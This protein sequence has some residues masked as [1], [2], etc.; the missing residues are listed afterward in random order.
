MKR[1]RKNVLSYEEKKVALEH[2]L[3]ADKLSVKEV[4][5]ELDVD[6][7]TVYMWLKKIDYDLSNIE[8]LNRKL[9]PI[10]RSKTIIKELDDAVKKK[11]MLLI[12]SNPEM[13][14]LKIKQYLFRHEQLVVSEKKIYFFLKE[15]GII[16]KRKKGLKVA[17]CH[18]RRFEYPAPLDAVQIDCLTVTVGSGLKVYVISILDDYS[19][20]ILG[21]RVYPKKSME[22]VMKIFREVTK[23][24]G[25]TETVITDK[26]SEF[27]S[28][29]SFTK[30]EELLCSL[31]IE[32]IA[33]GPSKPQN[34]GKIERWHQ[35]FRNE[36][37]RIK[38]PFDYSSQLQFEL[39]EFV[40]YYNYERPHQA[41]N[42][43]VPADRFFGLA[44]PIEKE[45]EQCRQVSSGDRCIY[46]SCNIDGRKVV[47]SGTRNG[48]IDILENGH[49]LSNE[50]R[51]EQNA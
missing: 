39:G 36:F 48:K 49:S 40:N 35:T 43:L 15:K 34:Q 41:L 24:Y 20:F 26:G 3:K 27:V 51:K 5:R 19:R 28:W 23:K 8:R 46:F 25:V 32:L 17:D 38:G 50:S 12:Q 6:R 11:V 29:Q 33:S 30:F 37:E 18:D 31:D 44:E 2:I 1:P 21:S 47:V 14:A 7:S 4:C 9:Q 13:G 16:D 42:G 22:N 10:M 45:L